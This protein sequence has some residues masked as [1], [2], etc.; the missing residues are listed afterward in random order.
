[1][2]KESFPVNI[3]VNDAENVVLFKQNLG[4]VMCCIYAVAYAVFVI[5]AIYD[6]NLMDKVMPFG[7]NLATFYGIGLIFFALLLSMVYS[8]A[9]T[10]K[11]K[12]GN[13]CRP[14]PEEK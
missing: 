4:V 12:A 13:V 2:K 3:E 6:V 1:M 7:L 5:I 11:E 14:Q 10:R 9:C 8:M